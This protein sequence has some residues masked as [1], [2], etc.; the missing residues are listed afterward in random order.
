LGQVAKLLERNLL[1]ATQEEIIPFVYPLGSA[2]EFRAVKQAWI[3][4]LT[5]QKGADGQ[6]SVPEEDA[7]NALIAKLELYA[8]QAEGVRALRAE[9]PRYIGQLTQR[10]QEIA[11]EIAAWEEKN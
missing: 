11:A 1:F 2:T 10:Q 9:L 3:T 5:V 8:V 4:W 6:T 7:V